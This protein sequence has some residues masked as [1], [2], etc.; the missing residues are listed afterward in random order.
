MAFEPET[1]IGR[2]KELVWNTWPEDGDWQNLRPPAPSY[3]R[4]LYLGRLLQDDD[5]ITKLKIPTSNLAPH[6]TIVHI[7]IRPYAPAKGAENNESLGKKRSLARR[8]S[9]DNMGDSDAGCCGCI[10]C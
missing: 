9:G 10:I 1:T 8:L 4:L 7:S 5:T 3:L 2:V 6:A